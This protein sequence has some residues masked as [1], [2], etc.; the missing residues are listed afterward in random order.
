MIVGWLF[1]EQQLILLIVLHYVIVIINL[2]LGLNPENN[3]NNPGNKWV[4]QCQAQ[5][6]SKIKKIRGQQ[7]RVYCC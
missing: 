4:I 7:R 6:Q 2:Y 3:H 1:K 5:G